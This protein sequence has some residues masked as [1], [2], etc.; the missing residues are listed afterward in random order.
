MLQENE[1]GRTYET[2]VKQ[3]DQ[4]SESLGFWTLSVVQ[5]SK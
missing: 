2:K 4:N 3:N 1:E 5:N